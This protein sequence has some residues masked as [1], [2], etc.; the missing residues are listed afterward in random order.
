MKIRI[1]S[2]CS[3]WIETDTRAAPPSQDATASMIS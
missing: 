1:S 3:Q 2:G